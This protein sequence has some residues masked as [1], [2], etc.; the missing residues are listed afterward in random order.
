MK[1]LILLFL[2]SALSYMGYGQLSPVAWQFSLEKIDQST[3]KV[4]CEAS[5]D[6]G[7]YV[8]SQFLN[9][10]EG[11]IPTKITIDVND[12]VSL[13]GKSEEIG[14]RKEGMDPIFEMMIVKFGKQATF[15]QTVKVDGAQ[16]ITGNI[17]FMT[18]DDE[19]CLPPT[20]EPFELQVK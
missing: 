19:Q 16:V 3:Y 2:F 1:N 9:P 12:E 13:A 4:N 11:P 7:W 10:D 18:C 14:D 17:E 8:Y 6:S 5:I 15:S 20:I